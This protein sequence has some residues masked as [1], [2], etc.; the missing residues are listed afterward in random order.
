MSVVR[1][2]RYF[3]ELFVRWAIV[4]LFI[5]LLL[6]G[7]AGT[8][9]VSSVQR[10]VVTFSALLIVTM[11]S[12]DPGLTQER[13]RTFERATTQGR[14]GAG[15]SF[16]A[17]L[18]C[19][20]MDVG[21]LHWLDSVPPET[22]MESLSLFI[23]ATSLQM[24]AMIV[25]PFFSPEIRLQPERGHCLISRGPYRLMRHPGYL[26]MLISVP[27]SALAIG[28]WLALVPAAIFC[29]VILK[30]VRAEEE[31]LQNNLAGYS[32]YMGQVRGQLFPRVSFRRRPCRHSGESTCASDASDRR[33]P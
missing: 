16:L 28:S 10:Y 21:R 11:L 32:E 33:W 27:A 2:I 23:A 7:A 3:L 17:T 22:Q 8:T 1:N 12:V 5:S 24:W 26:A 4:T 30:R 14:F 6:F 9:G 13:S 29:L 25:N 31:F 19:A 15:L 18:G 20:A